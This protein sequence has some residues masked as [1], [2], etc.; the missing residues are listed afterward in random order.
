MNQKELEE[1]IKARGHY[2]DVK[3]LQDGTVVG[4]G[5][6]VFTRAIYLDMDL[7]GWGRRFCYSDEILATVE[8]AKLVDGDTEPQG[9]IARR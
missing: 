8:Y 7:N 4:L 1:E 2:L 5:E 9:Y 6:L 3:T